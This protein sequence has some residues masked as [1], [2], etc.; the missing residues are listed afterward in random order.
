M[1][2]KKINEKNS[3]QEEKVGRESKLRHAWLVLSPRHIDGYIS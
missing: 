3:T 1:L 2:K